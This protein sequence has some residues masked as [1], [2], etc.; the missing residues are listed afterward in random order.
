MKTSFDL[1]STLNALYIPSAC[2]QYLKTNFVKTTQ[3]LLLF[4]TTNSQVSTR[5][6]V[7]FKNPPIFIASW[8]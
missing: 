2:P 4:L 8:I 6:E 1:N 5:S 7:I 3:L